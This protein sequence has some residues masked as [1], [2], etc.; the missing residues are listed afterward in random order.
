MGEAGWF[1]LEDTMSDVRELNSPL[2][3]L[4]LRDG[5]AIPLSGISPDEIKTGAKHKVPHP[6]VEPQRH[7]QTLSAIVDR[8]GFRGDFGD[9]KN[10]GWDSFNAFLHENNC[11]DRGRLFPSDYGECIDL[12]FSPKRGPTRRRLADRIFE[13]PMPFPERV[14]LGYGV[15]WKAWDGGC[16]YY[17]PLEAVATVGGDP[18]TA[19]QRAIK[20][21]AHR[22]SLH[23]QFGFL[24]DKLI[25]GP[26]H[27]VIDKT[28]WLSGASEDERQ[29]HK[30]KV[31]EATRAFRSVFDTQAEGWV[32]VLRY[33]DRLVVLRAHDGSWDVLWRGYRAEEPPKPSDICSWSHLAI[34]DL[35]RHL[36]IESDPQRFV[37][38]RQEVWEELEAHEAEQAFYDRGGSGLDRQYTDD[39]DVR[40]AWLREHDRFPVPERL[41]FAEDL[42]K[43]FRRVEVGGR[44]LAV[45]ELIDLA[46]FRRMLVETGYLE[47]RDDSSEPWERAN[48]GE[49]DTVPVGASWADAQAF[50]A[51]KERQL[52]VDLRLPTKDE[53]RA[54]HPIHAGRFQGMAGTQFRWEHYPPF[55]LEDADGAVQRRDV[56]S[57]LVWSEP[58]F[59]EPGPGVDEFPATSGYIETSRKRWITDFPPRA[60]W[61][62]D[63]PTAKYSGL[64]FIDAWDAYEWCQEMG[65][66]HG[67]FWDGLIGSTSWGAYKNVKVTFRLVLDLEG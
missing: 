37:H 35:P 28:Y 59:L 36:M 66:I 38:F 61:R 46:S 33:N 13:S 22:H 21:F 4:L 34:E 10:G 39:V 1:F 53:L 55:P 65:W 52:G 50:C 17:V 29:A 8:L 20:L 9:F 40:I 31:V 32:D 64:R 43:G 51:W 45:S 25:W 19:E 30:A 14:F 67:R 58:R 24:D 3:F 18:A 57:A 6:D 7:R 27:T 5:H 42:P 41:R 15:D 44:S 2:G 26:V 56:P 16:G 12:H 11:G 54:L 63:L 23:G 62:D 60:T 48:E 49:P 47:R